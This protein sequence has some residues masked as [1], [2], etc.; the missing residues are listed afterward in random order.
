[1]PLLMT[2]TGKRRRWPWLILVLAGVTLFVVEADE[3]W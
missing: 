1:M 2:L 3:F